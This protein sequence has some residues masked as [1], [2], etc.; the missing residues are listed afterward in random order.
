MISKPSLTNPRTTASEHKHFNHP[1]SLAKSTT[2]L[3]KH[4]RIAKL[5][6]L[7]PMT[8]IVH[9]AFHVEPSDYE[10]NTP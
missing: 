9:P 7:R 6:S 5:V 10:D 8:Q 2:L 1:A 4:L 3:Y